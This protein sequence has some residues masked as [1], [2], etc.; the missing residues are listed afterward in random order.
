MKKILS[1]ALVT[2]LSLSLAAPVSAGR[3]PGG[4]FQGGFHHD[5]FRHG[6]FH[7]DGF[8]RFGC[9]FGPAFVGGIFV[10]SAFAYPYYAYP[11]AAYPG[12]PVYAPAPVYE[13]QTQVP[14]APSIQREVCYT[15][16]CYHLQ[17][18]GVTVAYVWIWVPAAP[19][20]PPAPPSR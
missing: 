4:G 12:Y 20:A 16:G 1:L 13:S 14:V 18:D 11:Y 7:H 8:H 2:A 9:C 15:S 5:G 10:G 3:G 19:A 17:G 6:G